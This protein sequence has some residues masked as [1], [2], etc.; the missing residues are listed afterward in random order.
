MSEAV[1]DRVALMRATRANLEP[2]L[3]IHPGMAGLAERL[4]TITAGEP[5]IAFTALDGTRHRLWPV[6]PPQQQAI[7]EELSTGPA[8]IAD[9]HHRYA[10]YRRLQTE[11]R[12]T[13]APDGESAWDYGLALV[14]GSGDDELRI[15]PIHRSVSGLTLSD[16]QELSVQRSDR[17]TEMPDRESAIA[18]ARG[19][20]SDLTGFVVS[21]GR[22]WAVLET[23]A[24]RPID[25]AVLHETLFPAWRVEEGQVGYH[26][27]LDQALH[28]LERH[29][30]VLV[31]VRPPSLEQVMSAAARGIRMPRKSTSFGPKPAMGVVLRDLDEA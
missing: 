29:P 18:G 16:V 28:G 27:S 21:D 24:T 13:D 30:G 31:A 19:P 22:R 11:Q 14:V 5:E 4:D 1:E 9:G 10:A 26:H 23:D 7:C 3:L 6:S 20:G 25:T 12:A 15:G 2:I 17:F 8:L